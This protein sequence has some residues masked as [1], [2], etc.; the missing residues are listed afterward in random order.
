M[1]CAHEFS[2]GR[3]L[4]EPLW[5]CHLFLGFIGV[6][7]SAGNHI[8][9]WGIL[10]RGWRPFWRQTARDPGTY[11]L[12]RMADRSMSGLVENA[13]FH[14]GGAALTERQPVAARCSDA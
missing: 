7:E 9:S 14:D 5:P 4:P 12:M 8:P 6:H 10:D 1:G 13:G 3:G 2:P 11:A